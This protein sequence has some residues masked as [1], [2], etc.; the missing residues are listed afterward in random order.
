MY[1]RKMKK[2]VSIAVTIILITQIILPILSSFVD[3]KISSKSSASDFELEINTVDE[4]WAFAEDVNNGNSYEGKKVIIFGDFDL[5]CD[6]SKPW[7]PIGNSESTA[8]Q[9]EF[10]GNGSTISG[11]YGESGIFGYIGEKGLVKMLTVFEST[12]STIEA[13]SAPIGGIA[14]YNKGTIENC[15]CRA[16]MTSNVCGGGI[17]GVNEGTI[18]SC[19]NTAYI[20]GTGILGGIAGINGGESGVTGRI[21]NCEGGLVNGGTTS[22]RNSRNKL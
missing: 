12:G 17:V 6:E 22:G 2:K 11:I 13:T 14:A 19:K 4:L 9:G 21:Y 1:I 7:I 8:F 16:F 15:V 18:N 20:Q 5:G 3:N 10:W